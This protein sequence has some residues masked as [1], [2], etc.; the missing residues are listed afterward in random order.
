MFVTNNSDEPMDLDSESVTQ[1]GKV[2]EIDDIQENQLD[3][4]PFSEN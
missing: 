3:F 4:K 2:E 1:I